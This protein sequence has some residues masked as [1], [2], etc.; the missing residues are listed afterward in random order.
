MEVVLLHG[1]DLAIKSWRR[2]GAAAVV[3]IAAQLLTDAGAEGGSQS[4]GSPSR[5]VWR[6]QVRVTCLLAQ[7]DLATGAGAAML[8]VH[9]DAARSASEDGSE[10]HGS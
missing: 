7:V 1:G 5:L 2:C 6:R 10:C 4:T 3:L 8:A 9:C